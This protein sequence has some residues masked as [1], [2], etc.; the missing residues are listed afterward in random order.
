LRAGGRPLDGF[1]GDV[2][3]HQFPAGCLGFVEEVQEELRACASYR[4]VADVDS[5]SILRDG[6][7][8]YSPGFECEIAALSAKSAVN[9][10]ES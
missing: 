5:L 9:F 10:A 8:P 3:R 2:K 7:E 4:R 6:E 1:R